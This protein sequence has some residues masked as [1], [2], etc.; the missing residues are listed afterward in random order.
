MSIRKLAVNTN[1]NVHRR[2]VS[3]QC[4]GLTKCQSIA[5]QY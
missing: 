1:A 4:V 5:K 3:V 2:D